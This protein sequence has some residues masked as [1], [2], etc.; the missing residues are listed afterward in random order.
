MLEKP[1]EKTEKKEI[2]WI[3]Q[4]TGGTHQIQPKDIRHLIAVKT[5]VPLNV[6]EDSGKMSYLLV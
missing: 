5:N 2:I 6:P 3:L 4:C 1:I